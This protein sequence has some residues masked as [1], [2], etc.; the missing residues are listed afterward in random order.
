MTIR[1]LL[2]GL[3]IGA[4]PWLAFGFGDVPAH[5]ELVVY[6]AASLTE[7]FTE[8]GELFEAQSPGV[9]V[10]FNFGGSSGLRLQLVHG[11]RADL[12]ASANE[13]EMKKVLG[14]GLAQEQEPFASNRLALVTPGANP[15]RIH[16]VRDLARPGLKLSLAH[17]EVPVGRC[18]W[19]LIDE[20][21]SPDSF[22]AGY[23][24]QVLRN[25]VSEET[26]VKQVLARVTL[27][28]V[29]AGFVYFSDL[30]S[31]KDLREVRLTP[32]RG[33]VVFYHV[34]VLKSAAHRELAGQFRDLILSD[35]GRAVLERHG[36]DTAG[37]G[38]DR[39]G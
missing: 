33:P 39:S 29:D 15:G 22:G 27:G 5:R 10:V 6:A 3:L 21:S 11:A 36:V 13:R 35:T 18:A 14:A 37:H 20:L 16:S 17:R 30:R 26:N 7:S 28:E 24:D 23:G 38:L 9:R 8:M 12:F 31:R 25:V 19:Q 32:G 2:L 4:G 34:A 1:K